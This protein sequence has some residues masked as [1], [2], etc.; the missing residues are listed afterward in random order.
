MHT[1]VVF[2]HLVVRV[3]VVKSVGVLA[4]ENHLADKVERIRN[5]AEARMDCIET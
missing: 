2:S 1:K 3:V 5:A 4:L